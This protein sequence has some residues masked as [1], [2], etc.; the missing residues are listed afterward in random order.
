MTPQRYEKTIYYAQI[1]KNFFLHLFLME[2]FIFM[3]QIY[4]NAGKCLKNNI[5]GR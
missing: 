3:T 4:Y 2:S 5:F 1:Y